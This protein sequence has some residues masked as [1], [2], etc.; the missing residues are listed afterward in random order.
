[1]TNGGP[2]TP[3][4]F[5]PWPDALSAMK[6]AWRTALAR[7]AGTTKAAWSSNSRKSRA[8]VEGVKRV[9]WMKIAID[10]V[11]GD[12]APG[13]VAEGTLPARSFCPK[14]LA[15]VGN[16]KLVPDALGGGSGPVPFPEVVHA[17]LAT[18]MEE[19]GFASK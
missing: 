2:T 16:E 18:S 8:A 11:G 10:A 14:D 5:R 12:H 6:C 9:C 3:L 17:P 7:T 1:M 13:S 15:R 4:P 19:W